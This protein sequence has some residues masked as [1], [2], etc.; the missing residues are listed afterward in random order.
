MTSTDLQNFHGSPA[1]S[2]PRYRTHT[3]LPLLSV[4]TNLP[5]K[6]KIIHDVPI[7]SS[8]PTISLSI[9]SAFPSM[10]TLTDSVTMS[11]SGVVFSYNLGSM[12]TDPHEITELLKATSSERGNWILV[13]AYYRRNSNPRAAIF[14]INS[15]LEVMAQHDVPEQELKPAYL[16]LSSCEAD[17]GKQA[18]NDSTESAEH[19]KNAQTWL[20]KVYGTFAFDGNPS[21]ANILSTPG[22]ASYPPRR[23]PAD[24]IAHK[25]DRPLPPPP[26]SQGHDKILQR[27]IQSLRDRLDH[28]GNL[29]ADV[30]CSKRK[31]EDEFNS[32]RNLRRRLERRIADLRRKQDATRG[33]DYHH[34]HRYQP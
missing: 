1:T 25:M 20:Q 12:K 16:L 34:G 4:T 33:M 15:L 24:T 7:D 6:P 22:M 11:L 28:Q 5:L 29:L 10:P 32:E 27:E 2:K 30:R 26:S 14:V 21:E 9:H 13:A 8:T 3:N 17:L 31:L 23:S 18:R 19:Y